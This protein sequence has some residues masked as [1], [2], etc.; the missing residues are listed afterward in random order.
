MAGRRDEHLA[1]GFFRRGRI[2]REPFRLRAV[3][4]Q[5]RILGMERKPLLQHASRIGD[6]PPL[7]EPESAFGVARGVGRLILVAHASMMQKSR[8]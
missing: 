6:A 1:H 2:V 4:E 7:D 5:I 8:H 3:E